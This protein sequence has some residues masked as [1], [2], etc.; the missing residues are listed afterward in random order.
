[1][2]S[3]RAPGKLYIA[4]E[5]AVVEP[6]QPAALVAVDR[7][8]TV[9]LVANSHPD[10]V[11]R[12]HS[13]AYDSG[14][15]VW[16][17]E[18][19]T[20]R[21]VVEHEPR[22]YVISAIRTVDRLRAER[23]LAPAYF[24]VHISSELEH[25][26]G[27]KYGLGSSAAVTVALI[28]ALDEFYQLG[29]SRTERFKLALLA[30]IQVSPRASGGDLAASTYGGWIRYTAPDR[31]AVLDHLEQHGVTSALTAPGWES[32]SIR[33]LPA[34]QGLELLVGWTGSPASTEILVAGVQP[35][36]VPY[37]SFLRDSRDCV[38]E[39]VAG[40]A[41]GPEGTSDAERVRRALW[42]ARRV[43]QRLG[44]SAGILLETET[45]RRLCDIAEAHGAGGKPSGA[46]GGDCGI[47]LTPAAGAATGILAEWASH[48]ITQ[49]HLVVHPPEGGGH[50]H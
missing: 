7:Y 17:R 4:G 44:T 30:T 45:L 24:D 46:G 13:S 6:G 11:G 36:G 9:Q 16:A 33:P 20:G 50:E 40:L 47:V 5:Y 31:S 25:A 42:N 2:I 1:M 28:A 15:L 38:D 29:L 8:L 18:N 10:E 35:S 41:P 27:R 23:S 39:L 14:P 37:H 21:I 26:G 3:T 34:P 49:L 19:D 43:L 22:D 12:V 48:A 32:F